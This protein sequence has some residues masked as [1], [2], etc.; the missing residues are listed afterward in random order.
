MQNEPQRKRSRVKLYV[1]VLIF[2]FFIVYLNTFFVIEAKLQ[3]KS[4]F[5]CW[6]Y[7]NLKKRD[8]KSC[9]CFLFH[10]FWKNNDIFIF[11]EKKIRIKNAYKKFKR[12]YF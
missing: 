1:F 8:K 11:K 12:V 2:N 6:S 7:V 10:I 5:Q 3:Y 9:K 4:S